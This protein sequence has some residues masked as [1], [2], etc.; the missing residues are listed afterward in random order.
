MVVNGKSL[1]KKTDIYKYFSNIPKY[2]IKSLLMDLNNKNNC[3]VN[4]SYVKPFIVD[5]LLHN[6]GSPYEFDGS[7]KELKKQRVFNKLY[8]YPEYLIVSRMKELNIEYG[9]NVGSSFVFPIV[10]DRLLEE[11]FDG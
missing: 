11:F 1:I 6:I 9:F 3:R 5:K 10:Y 7:L 4:G 2:V 8:P